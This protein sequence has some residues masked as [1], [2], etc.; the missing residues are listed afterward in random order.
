MGVQFAIDTAGDFRQG[1]HRPPMVEENE[2]YA[3]YFQPAK[4]TATVQE[5]T[6]DHRFSFF[7]VMHDLDA[8]PTPGRVYASTPCL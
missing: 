5:D 2:S 1:F 8:R 3:A 7:K 4:G 6:L